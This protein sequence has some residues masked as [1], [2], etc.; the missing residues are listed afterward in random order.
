MPSVTEEEWEDEKMVW[1]APKEILAIVMLVNECQRHAPEEFS[2]NS[3]LLKRLGGVKRK[4]W[5]EIEDMM[6]PDEIERSDI[7]PGI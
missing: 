6:R 3:E 7:D 4:L 2:I 5:L 1:L